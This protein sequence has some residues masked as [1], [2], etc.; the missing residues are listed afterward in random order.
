M[1]RLE[2]PEAKMLR[3]VPCFH[4][5]NQKEWDFRT[6]GQK[7]SIL[8]YE[9]RRGKKNLQN[10]GDREGGFRKGPPG[11]EEWGWC[12]PHFRCVELKAGQAGLSSTLQGIQI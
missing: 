5:S 10:R 6:F 7:D 12:W 3:P 11:S 4:M 2:V 1:K 8:G 9:S